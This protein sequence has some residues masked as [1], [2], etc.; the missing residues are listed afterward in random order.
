MT[1]CRDSMDIELCGLMQQKRQRIWDNFIRLNFNWIFHLHGNV[2]HVCN[3]EINKALISNTAVNY[4]SIRMLLKCVFS[5]DAGCV[6]SYHQFASNQ[7]HYKELY[8]LELAFADYYVRVSAIHI[9]ENVERGGN[10]YTWSVYNMPKRVLLISGA[11][12]Y[13]RKSAL[14]RHF[15]SI[16]P[17]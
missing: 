3:C 13:R 7:H 15:A 14:V 5:S 1:I 17:R 16:V 4:D 11:Q 2:V 10:K 12:F 9:V 6:Q 8:R